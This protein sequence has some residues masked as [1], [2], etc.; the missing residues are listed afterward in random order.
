M[1]STTISKRKP[2]MPA[3][4]IHLRL[5]KVTI[6]GLLGVQQVKVAERLE[7]RANF[8][9][10]DKN[11]RVDAIPVGQ[12]VVL[13]AASFISH[14][15]SAAAKKAVVGTS[16]RLVIHHGGVTAMVRKLDGILPPVI[17]NEMS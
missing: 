8:N 3:R 6:V 13:L 12:D 11:R 2:L 5:P 15:M 14:S 9:F 7:G 1:S 16:T 17:S 10:V 4:P